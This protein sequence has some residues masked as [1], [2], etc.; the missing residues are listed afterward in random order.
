MK[1]TTVYLDE[2]DLARLRAM[3]RR[4]RRAPAELI[5]LAIARLVGDEPRE[6]PKGAG[7][8]R[9][10]QSDVSASRRKILADAARKRAL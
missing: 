3:A 4:E 5:R 8:Y 9:S 10:G 6:L 2:A 7:S 1:K